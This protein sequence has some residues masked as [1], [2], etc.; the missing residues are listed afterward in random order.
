MYVAGHPVDAVQ[1]ARI[2][3]SARWTSAGASAILLAV[4]QATTD[5]GV[6]LPL[7]LQGPHWPWLAGA[8]LFGF[9][10]AW[11]GA[12][13][14]GWGSLAVLAVIT[15]RMI[16]LAVSPPAV[17]IEPVKFRA[18]CLW[19][20]G[21]W[22]LS[23]CG[24]FGVRKSTFSRRELVSFNRRATVRK[25]YHRLQVIGQ[26]DDLEVVT[27]PSNYGVAARELAGLLNDARLKAA[28]AIV[29]N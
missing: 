6:A 12:H 24:E 26:W 13:S 20:P 19:G 17:T 5:D 3:R 27:L 29:P 18:S 10:L 11:S 8:T 25:W 28:Q 14:A 16:Q 7:R 2:C 23:E 4:G 1:V 22:L 21:T 9:F 15:A